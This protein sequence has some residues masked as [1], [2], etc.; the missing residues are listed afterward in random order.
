MGS[1]MF[2]GSVFNF[3]GSAVTK[4]AGLSHKQGGAWVDVT[5][6][7]D[8]NKIFEMGQTDLEIRVKFKGRCSLTFKA[9]GTCSITWSDGTTSPCPGTWQVGPIE[10]SGDW[11]APVTGSVELRP[12]VA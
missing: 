5:V 2:N 10:D 9:K 7:E 1:R 8:L 6:P 12:T 4:L 11:D 3:N